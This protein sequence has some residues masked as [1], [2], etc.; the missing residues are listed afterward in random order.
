M[1]DAAVPTKPPP[2]E[3]QGVT[4]A[5]RPTDFTPKFLRKEALNICGSVRDWPV[6]DP[7]LSI[8]GPGT[9]QTRRGRFRIR[10]QVGGPD[11]TGSAFD[12][13]TQTLDVH[14]MTNPFVANLVPG[15]S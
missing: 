6:V 1:A 2:F 15:D 10:D 5:F 3:R 7:L 12:P 11:W 8:E 4:E 13:D 9:E 14:S